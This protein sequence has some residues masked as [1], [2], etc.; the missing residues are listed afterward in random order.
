M[1][2]AGL[3][4]ARKAEAKVVPAWESGRRS[5]FWRFFATVRQILSNP[6]EFFEGLSISSLFKAFTFGWLI[7]SLAVAFFCGYSLW[8]L[9]ANRAAHL[10]LLQSHPELIARGVTPAQMLD[11]MREMLLFSLFLAPLLGAVNVWVSAGL[12]HLGVMLAAG[13]N[14]GFVATF[15]ATAYGFVPLLLLAVPLV[16]HLIGGLWSVGLQIVAIRQIHRIEFGRAVLA[17]LMPLLG[18]LLLL[19]WMM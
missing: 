9:D 15:R 6:R 12:N 10:E 1:L 16:G 5:V 17:V 8:Q 11:S 14:R 4:L 2:A 13:Q 19:M 3:R 7:A 18:V